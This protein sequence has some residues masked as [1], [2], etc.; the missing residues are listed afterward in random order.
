MGGASSHSEL[1]RQAIK[2][3]GIVLK[4]MHN[5]VQRYCFSLQDR[6]LTYYKTEGSPVNSI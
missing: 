4:V 5:S 2:R 3:E 6:E 1:K